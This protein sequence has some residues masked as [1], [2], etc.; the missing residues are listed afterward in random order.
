MRLLAA[1]HGEE[2][3]RWA[4]A[5][6]QLLKERADAHAQL[7]LALQQMEQQQKNQELHNGAVA[8]PSFLYP[9]LLLTPCCD[10]YPISCFDA[11]PCSAL[12]IR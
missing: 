1:Q 7:Q 5:H 11:P 12:W 10:G 3:R 9:P 4:G 8:H 2:A 6:D